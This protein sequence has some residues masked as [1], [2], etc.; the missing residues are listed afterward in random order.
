MQIATNVFSL[1]AQ[2]QLD[3]S[4]QGVARTLQRLSSGLRVNSAADDAAGLSIGSR[5]EALIRGERQSV[6]N[7]N[8]AISM[9]QVTE[10][11]MGSI[12]DSLQRV[13]ELAVQAASDSL[14]ASDRAALQQEAAALLQGINQISEQTEFNGK[15]VFAQTTGSIGG[16]D[17][18]IRAVVDGLRLGWL[19]EAESLIGDLYGIYGDGASLTVNLTFTDG[20]G[21]VAASVS[22]VG[23]P[24]GKVTDQYLNIDMA[25]F[26]PPNLPDGGNAPFY[27]DRIIAH[28]M[29]HAVMG[30]AMNFTALPN[31]FKEGAAE[32][33][34][35]A[36][37]RLTV[38]YNGGAGMATLLAAFNADNVSASA[39]YSAGYA[40]VRYMHDQ[41]KASGGTGIKDVMTYLSANAGSTLDQALTNASSGA[42]AS[43]ADFS[44]QFNADAA[45]FIASM[46]LG[47]ADTGAIGGLD[48]D[49]R[50]VKSAT[51]VL[52]DRGTRYSDQ[53]LTSFQ[54]T[55]PGGLT[56]GTGTQQL[57]FQVGA[58]ARQ[59]ISVT[60]GGVSAVNLG[61]SDIDL[62]N[63]ATRAI[64]HIDQAIE[65]IAAERAKLGGVMSR[66][67]MAV[68]AAQ[69]SEEN[70][71]AA[72]SRIMDAD[73]AKE[74]TEL[75]RKQILQQAGIAML[76]QANAMPNLALQL[77]RAA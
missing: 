21:G 23:A 40:A 34:H 12:S 63:S 16:D 70:T 7:I 48:A 66:F 54:L 31:W 76:A 56:G 49:G 44:T 22:G 61:V 19:E 14:S 1:N 45:S 69:R 65:Y 57:A 13:R 68:Q 18:N 58:S 2:R 50:A 35:G 47:N 46:D 11:A 59:T 15:K 39:G 72:R 53:P 52:T 38:D 67:E 32:F 62:G 26:S 42:F 25:D 73:F 51:T 33:I 28:E 5:M 75:T 17:P 27:N 74:T 8:D 20:A 30:R 55:W 9:V 77:L 43:L 4:G 24:G 41:I 3:L 36:D 6:R 37:E 29:V 71:S 60:T 10:G 64:V